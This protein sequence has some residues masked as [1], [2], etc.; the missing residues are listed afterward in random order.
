MPLL[1]VIDQIEQA[2]DWVKTRPTYPV[3][4]YNLQMALERGDPIYEWMLKEFDEE[5]E[6]VKCPQCGNGSPTQYGRKCHCEG[7]GQH[8]EIPDPFKVEVQWC[9]LP[10]GRQVYWD[11]YREL[12][13]HTRSGETFSPGPE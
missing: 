3:M 12:W 5:Q 10:D 4:K 7:C 13:V 11:R 2:L 8:W 9:F 1:L 6:P